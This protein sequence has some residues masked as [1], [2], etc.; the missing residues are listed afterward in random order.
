MTDI[1]KVAV[2]GAGLFGAWAMPH[3]AWLALAALGAAAFLYA[4]ARI[5]QASKGIPA[6]RTRPAS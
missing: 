2:F 6:W 1:K 5:L 3:P 4:Q